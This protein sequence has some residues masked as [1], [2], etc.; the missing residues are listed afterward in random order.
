MLES[1]VPCSSVVQEKASGVMFSQFSQILLSKAQK[2][3]P[4][5]SGVEAH[6]GVCVCVCVCVYT[7]TK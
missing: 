3:D 1:V 2:A 5:R 6:R 7:H 4:I